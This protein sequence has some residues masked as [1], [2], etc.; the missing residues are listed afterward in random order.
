[1]ADPTGLSKSKARRALLAIFFTNPDQEYFVRQLERLT[2]IYAA[3]LQRELVKMEKS[4]LLHPRTLGNTK[5][6]KLNREHP[7]YPE[8]KGL[9]SKTAGL[10]ETIR[11]ELSPLPG[12]QAAYIYGSFARD[13][14]RSTSDVDLLILGEVNEKALIPAV[15]HLEKKLQREVNYTLYTPQQWKKKKTNKDSFVLEVLR[16]P[17]IVL[18]GDPNA[19]R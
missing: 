13:E 15:K 19:I 18:L 2:S 8:L 10:E 5:L 7:L 4:G 17:R 12:I 11:S 6:Y 1:M 16:Q 14:E 9:V 3:N